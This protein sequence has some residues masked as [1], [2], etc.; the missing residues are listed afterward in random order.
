MKPAWDKLAEEFKDSP[1]V[2][3]YDVDCTAA[4]EKLCS[5]VGVQGYPTIKYYLADVPKG[6][7]Y[8]GGRDLKDLKKFVEKTFKA[9]C[10]PQ[11]KENCSES[12]ITLIDELNKKSKDEIVAYAKS[13][14]EELEKKKE[15]RLKFIEES[16]QKIKDMKKEEEDLSTRL[17]MAEKLAA[18][19]E[20]KKKEEL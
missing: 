16:K 19:E 18:P 1:A 8:Q 4:G 13:V 10:K 2:G 12:Q 15:S 14:K 9:G 5:K 7:D 3:V 20:E 6:K 11:T 17:R